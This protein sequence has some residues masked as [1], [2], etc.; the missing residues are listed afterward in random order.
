MYVQIEFRYWSGSVVVFE[1]EFRGTY[2]ANDAR[3]YAERTLA[4]NT[5]ISGYQLLTYNG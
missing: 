2:A 1:R 4:Q 5:R 3:R